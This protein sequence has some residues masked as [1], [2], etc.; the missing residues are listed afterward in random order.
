MRLREFTN[1]KEQ[2]GLLRRIIDSTWTAIAD[3]AAEQKKQQELER[4]KASK[5]P[6]TKRTK[7]AS[8]PRPPPLVPR[9]LPKPKTPATAA[10]TAVL[11]KAPVS[12]TP[13]QSSVSSQQ[14]HV[15]VANPVPPSLVVQAAKPVQP[16][17]MPSPTSPQPAILPYDGRALR[18][19]YGLGI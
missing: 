14:S 12:T 9:T 3:E 15:S 19:K 8:S 6:R 4:I 10:N 5:K 11:S 1:A 16:P 7:I 2:L 18:K 17:A 13:A